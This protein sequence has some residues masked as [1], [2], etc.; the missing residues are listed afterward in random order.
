M[1]IGAHNRVVGSAGIATNTTHLAHGS[2]SSRVSPVTPPTPV[3]TVPDVAPNH[4]VMSLHWQGIGAMAELNHLLGCK[5]C[6]LIEA[7]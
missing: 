4:M 3:A 7:T 5:P 1:A 6:S 2:H